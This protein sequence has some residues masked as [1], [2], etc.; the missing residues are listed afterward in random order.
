[1]EKTLDNF[2][3]SLDNLISSSSFVECTTPQYDPEKHV[4]HLIQS[5][6]YHLLIQYR[7]GLKQILDYYFTYMLNSVGVDLFML[8]PSI[9][10]PMGP[11]SDSEPLPI[12]FGKYKSFLVDSSQFGFEP[13]LMNGIKSVHCYLP[14]MRGE[15]PDERHLNQFYHCEAEMKCDL[16]EIKKEVENAVRFLARKLLLMDS[17]I[18][19]ISE[20]VGATR[21]ALQ[22]IIECKQFPSITFD[23]AVDILEKNGYES[24]VNRTE[25]GKDIS[26]NG[27]KELMRVLGYEVPVWITH[28]DRDRVP[29][30]Q[31]VDPNNPEK[32]LNADLL[33]PPL[34]EGGFCGEI[35]GAGQRQDD[36]REMVESLRRQGI[37][38]NSY[39]WY[40]ALRGHASYEQTSGFGMGVE[41][42]LA[43]IL[44]KRSIRDVSLYPRLK[45]V[46]TYP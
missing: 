21:S 43:W 38:E 12:P 5:E 14:S 39:E 31:K 42:F 11:G 23:D 36:M 45:N 22:S 26:A 24:F 18:S 44:C 6:Y 37:A 41:R 16:Q 40:I 25:H 15:D 1:M 2:L 46:K 35:I 28:F 29:F 17:I 33:F 34:K 7:H 20:D 9:S 13:L 8:T 3:Q 10:S 27:E 19:Y 4:E 32:V 30:Y